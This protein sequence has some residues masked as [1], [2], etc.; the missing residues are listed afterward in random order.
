MG[1]VGSIVALIG[2]VNGSKNTSEIHYQLTIVS[3]VRRPQLI[4]GNLAKCGTD[5]EDA[6]ERLLGQGSAMSQYSE[7]THFSFTERQSLLL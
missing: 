4:G 2:H 7:E 5:C 1:P 3:T 6:S